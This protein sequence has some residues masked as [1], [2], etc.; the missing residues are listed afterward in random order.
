MRQ[1]I[2]LTLVMAMAGGFAFAD[3]EAEERKRNAAERRAELRRK[4]KEA[5]ERRKLKE[6]ELR[7]KRAEAKS[8]KAAENY[9]KA[10][11]RFE[12]NDSRSRLEVPIKLR[13]KKKI[14]EIGQTLTDTD[15][16]DEAELVAEKGVVK[17]V[18]ASS[19]RLKLSK[20]KS[21]LAKV[22]CEVDARRMTLTKH[23]TV[24]LKG[25][26]TGWRFEPEKAKRGRRRRSYRYTPGKKTE[27]DMMAVDGIR[28]FKWT[29]PNTFKA[30]GDRNVKLARIAEILLD[31]G[32]KGK[33][34]AYIAEVEME[35]AKQVAQ[36]P[37]KPAGLDGDAKGGKPGQGVMG[38]D[39]ELK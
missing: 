16:I 34:S 30:G 38:G 12:K 13:S 7:E 35:G 9:K 37:K 21:T 8:Q 20:L 10:L 6:A 22:G 25:E 23:F 33:G 5:A 32:S 27:N 4:K 26:M 18:L 39:E 36:K 14:D 15:E 11:E 19:A 3:E 29:G 17:I 31:H 1:L 2:L 24:T 28:S